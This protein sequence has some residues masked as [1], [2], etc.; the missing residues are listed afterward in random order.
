MSP[1][2]LHRSCWAS[3]YK[4]SGRNEM[5]FVSLC[6]STR[7]FS[8]VSCQTEPQRNLLSNSISFDKWRVCLLRQV[9]RKRIFPLCNNLRIKQE[10]NYKIKDLKHDEVGNHPN[11]NILYIFFKK[12]H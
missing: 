10:N 4:D 7:A 2:K 6:E 8:S 12:S 9:F 3:S 1:F 11:V 5:S